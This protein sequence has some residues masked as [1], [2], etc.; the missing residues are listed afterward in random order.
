ML[1]FRLIDMLERQIVGGKKALKFTYFVI[2]AKTQMEMSD[3]KD[4]QGRV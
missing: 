3:G 2:K 1:P 4:A